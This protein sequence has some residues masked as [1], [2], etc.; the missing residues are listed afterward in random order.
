MSERYENGQLRE[1]WDDDT[2][3]HT[4]YDEA[5]AVIDQRPYTSSE[6]ENAD[7][8]ADRIAREE[9]RAQLAAQLLEGIAEIEAARDEA[10]ADIDTATG[11]K[12]QADS[13]A[14]AIGTQRGSVLAW[15]PQKTYTTADLIAIRDQ[16]AQVLARQEQIV[17]ALSSFY[18]Y[19]VAVDRNAVQTDNAL[20]W[21]AQRAT[22]M[23]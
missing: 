13:L 18:A 14:T 2:R 5:G 23:L 4:T 22:N 9:R 20:L 11:L 10:Q 3:T 17:D 19:R 15:T 21:L 6:E 16:L 12:A 7:A 8:E 1:R